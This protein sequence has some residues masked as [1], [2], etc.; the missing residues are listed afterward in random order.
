MLSA[1]MF[2]LWPYSLRLGVWYLSI[3]VLCLLGAFFAMAILRLIF[4]CITVVVAKPGIWIFPRLFEDV[5]F[6]SP[7]SLSFFPL[8]PSLYLGLQVRLALCCAERSFADMCIL[9]LSR[10][11]YADGLLD[12]SL[13][14]GR[15]D[16]EEVIQ[17]FVLV[18]YSQ[19][20]I[21]ISKGIFYPVCRCTKSRYPQRDSRRDPRAE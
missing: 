9:H 2:P 15:P 4:Y 5:S 18:L 3:G 13:G 1:V 12:S 19:I 17:I 16:K 20:Q 7:L 10:V 8:L 6:V 21:E 14:L 11:F